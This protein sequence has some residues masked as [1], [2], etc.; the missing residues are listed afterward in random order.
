MRLSAR[1]R[2]IVLASSGLAV[3]TTLTTLVATADAGSRPPLS[4]VSA[5]K[6]VVPVWRWGSYLELSDLGVYL[7]TGDRP[8]EIWASRKDYAS[9]VTGELRIG[10]GKHPKVIKLPTGLAGLD[11]LQEFVRVQLV[12]AGGRTRLDYS[13]P[14]CG[15][16]WYDGPVR[17][18]PDAPDSSPYPSAGCSAHPFSLS[19][20][21]GFQSS[22][23]SVVSLDTYDYEDDE[24]VVDT[25]A[26]ALPDGD[27][28]AKVTLGSAW[29]KALGV[30]AAQGTAS[31]KIRITTE[32]DDGE[33][34]GEDDGSGDGSGAGDGE[35]DALPEGIRSLAEGPGPVVGGL[36]MPNG[37]GTV[38]Q[39]KD[40]PLGVRIPRAY[41][42]KVDGTLPKRDATDRAMGRTASGRPLAD[43]SRSE[44]LASAQGT[45]A[46]AAKV[47]AKYRPDL[48]TLPAFGFTVISP[49]EA[50]EYGQPGYEA[51]PGHE[52]L[53]FA[54]T[55]WN[56]GPGPLVV[57]GFRTPGASIM[58]AYQSFY[59]EN[60]KR[61][62]YAPSGSMEYDP[63]PGH[64]HWHFLDFA[65]YRLR[66]QDGSTVRSQKEAFC[67]APT[68][69][70]DLSVKGAQW[71]PASTGLSTACGYTSALGIRETLESGWGDTYGQYLPGQAFDITGLPNGTYQVEVVAN[72][73]GHLFETSTSNNISSR[74]IVLG[75]KPGAR[76]VTVPK[77][78]LVDAP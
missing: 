45:G 16:G 23:G 22:T 10:K 70:V 3:A 44:A 57:D 32:D 77:V 74:T 11:G 63:R 5:T 1:P 41:A 65:T 33:D 40:G 13:P 8:V 17:L 78:G 18:T 38:T 56:A 55:V 68:D 43:P 72:P 29:R 26:E 21:Y 46:S 15:G 4:L 48:R 7:T 6:D 19:A 67:L 14:F 36:V 69:A 54:A 49:D 52:Y 37:K 30:S 58:Q 50:E 75:G 20:L 51:E 34:D 73:E 76:T 60:G 28:T 2:T 12:D 27:Y 31:V 62:T 66:K 25:S 61:R 64:E 59:D 47:P 71:K 24:P 9:P 39:A 42:G 35:G 53:A